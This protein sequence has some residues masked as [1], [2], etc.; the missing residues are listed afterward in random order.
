MPKTFAQYIIESI[1]PGDMEVTKPVDKAYLK[2]LLSEVHS[3]YPATYSRV[4]VDLKNFGDKMS[5]LDGGITIG[6]DEI[7]VPN[8]EKRDAII[9]KYRDKV[10]KAKSEDEAIGYMERA[11]Q[12]M[13]ANDLHG[14]TDDATLMVTSGGLGGKRAQ[15]MKLRSTP[16]VVKGNDG[17]IVPTFFDKSYAEGVDPLH[18]WI[19]AAESRRNLAQGQVATSE[20]GEFAK[21][22]AN[23]LNDAVVSKDDCG[24]HQ[25]ITLAADD[26]EILGRY[27]AAGTGRFRRNTLITPEVQQELISAKTDSVLVRSPQTCNAGGNTVCSRCMGISNSTGKPYSV[28]DNVGMLTATSLS[29]PLTQLSLSAKHSTSLAKKDTGLTGMKGLNTFMEMPKQFDGKKIL[30]EVYGVVQLIQPAPQGGKNIIIRQTRKVPDRYIVNGKK[31]H[32]KGTFLYYIPPNIQVVDDLEKGS[33]VYPGMALS[34]GFDNIKDVARLRNLGVAR[35]ASATGMYNI[36]KNSG[37]KVDRRHTELLARAAHNYVKIEKAPMSFPFARGEVVQ[38]SKFV[39]AMNKITGRQVKLEDAIGLSLV[40]PVGSISVGTEIT[41]QLAS[42]LK[43]KGVR[44]VK[45]TAQ[46]EVSPHTTP[47]TR[48]MNQSDEWVAKMN[49]RYLKDTLKN[50]ALFGQKESIH[51]YR[52]ITAYAYGAEFGLGDKGKY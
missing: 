44:R 10:K 40:E 41:P 5:T 39:D 49:H 8:K 28:G 50:A 7:R 12:E 43:S 2:D 18:E 37:Q 11:Q 4:V 51:G 6:M 35:S 32:T 27:L 30:C 46:V 15:L 36:F 22:Y 24:T 23:L 42:Q 33:E 17:K 52:P 21:V 9:R 19:Q 13:A 14:M 31:Y 20:P 29:E 3:K 45:V 16:V 47:L 1:L 48:T 25:G 38:Y 26:E 34:T